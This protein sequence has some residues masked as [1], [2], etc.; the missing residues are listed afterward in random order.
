MSKPA[1]NDIKAQTPAKPEETPV[2]PTDPGGPIPATPEMEPQKEEP[3]TGPSSPDPEIPELN[4]DPIP[5]Q[6]PVRPLMQNL[7]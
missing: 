3:E 1:Y 5:E 7:C 2:R 4:P 6:D